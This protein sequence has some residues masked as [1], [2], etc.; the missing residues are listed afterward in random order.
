M[1][2]APYIPADFNVGHAVFSGFNDRRG[3]VLCGYEW[4][5][6]KSDQSIEQGSPQHAQMQAHLALPNT[7]H[8]KAWP[9]SPYERRLLKWF[10]LFG[11]PLG[12][13][14]GFSAFDKSILQT[15][16]C[17]DQAYAVD[18]YDKFLRE[19]NSTNFLAHMREFFPALIIFLGTRQLECLQNET[20]LPAFK[21]IFG[22][23][24]SPLRWETD[25]RFSGRKFRI[26]FQK[27]Q[28][29]SIISLPHPSGT[30]GLSDEYVS[31]F[32][33]KIGR[34][35]ARYKAVKGFAADTQSAQDA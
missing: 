18:D 22:E 35:I 7:F 21:A 32:A 13:D 10:G 25:D 1:R 33:E 11:H 9:D 2:A 14:G 17:A 23:E 6:T 16:W 27:F 30:M 4:G 20:V 5:H 24:T 31:L 12:E 29:V 26:G 3:L 15:N 8:A 19:E 28:N 34:E